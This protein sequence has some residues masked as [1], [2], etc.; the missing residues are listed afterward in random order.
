MR[1]AVQLKDRIENEEFSHR[2]LQG[3]GATAT[4]YFVQQLKMYKVKSADLSMVFD[5][6]DT[7]RSN[8]VAVSIRTNES[9][10]SQ[11]YQPP[12]MK[13]NKSNDVKCPPPS[14]IT[15]FER[16]AYKARK[17]GKSFE[18]NQDG[19][20]LQGLIPQKRVKT[21]T[22]TNDVSTYKCPPPPSLMN[23]RYAYSKAQDGA[24]SPTIQQAIGTHAAPLKIIRRRKSVPQHRCD[25]FNRSLPSILKPT[26]HSP[27]R[28]QRL[29]KSLPANWA[30]GTSDGLD[31]VVVDEGRLRN[32]I[33]RNSMY[34]T[35]AESSWLPKGV[36][37]ALNVEVSF[38]RVVDELH[39]R[40]RVRKNQDR[41]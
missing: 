7:I 32:S 37:F 38:Y 16:D 4:R 41:V 8:P 40:T 30:P 2:E 35:D 24:Q 31:E 26:I 25:G 10:R 11:M 19:G 27:K 5:G 21:P 15:N 28:D 36:D 6:F 29:T 34:N 18:F 3:H 23:D 33:L 9:V 20:L 17:A 14:S 12:W 13:N 1:A 39:S 22:R